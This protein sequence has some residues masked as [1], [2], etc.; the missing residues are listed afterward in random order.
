MTGVLMNP[1]PTSTVM[2][3][4]LHICE[5]AMILVFTCWLN[6]NAAQPFIE[7]QRMLRSEVSIVIVYDT[8]QGVSYDGAGNV[9]V[10]GSTS[11]SLG[12]QNLGSRDAYVGKFS[13][14]GDQLWLKQFGTN[15]FDE[16]R[17]T[18]SAD[19]FGNAY[20]AGSTFGA[21][22]GTNAGSID[23]F[24]V[25]Y[26]PNGDQVWARQIGSRDVDTANG[27]STVG[28][29]SVY[30]A[31]QTD[32]RVGVASYGSRD[33]FVSRY[34][35]LGNRDWLSQ[36]GTAQFEPSLGVAAD[37]LGNIFIVGFVA[38][39]NLS[40]SNAFVTKFDANGNQV[41]IQQLGTPARD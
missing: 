37:A 29:G 20:L 24:F 17:S 5:S 6:S 18:V 26:S 13:S 39:P 11:G 15:L 41:W 21:I 27:I 9:F 1:S 3:R 40:D 10:A 34:D 38:P 30:V 4:P 22:G 19:S 7:W 31:G 16:V 33:A 12:G 14:S 8:A 36:F 28:N 23:A 32:G 2:V 35:S 25:K